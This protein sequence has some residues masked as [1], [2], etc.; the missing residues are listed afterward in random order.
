MFNFVDPFK[1][2]QSG[3]R[4]ID[5][6]VE[7]STKNLKSK[8]A[9]ISKME[10]KAWKAYLAVFFAAG[11]AAALIWAA[12]ISWYPA[13][14][15]EEMPEVT[16]TYH[17]S[18]ASRK[19]GEEFQTQIVLD[20]AGKNIVAVQTVATFDISKVEVKSVDVSSSTSDFNSE[21]EKDIDSGGGR[22]LIAV[23]RST[24]GVKSSA[25]KV[26]T[27]SMKA[28]KDFN[29]PSL[30]LKPV[31][32]DLKDSSLAVV[33]DGKGS[34]VLQKVAYDVP[35]PLPTDVTPPVRSGGSPT[36]N[37]NAGATQA[38]LKVTTNE[39]STCKHSSTAGTA[40]DT[41]S[42]SFTTTDNLNHTAN[43]TGLANGK[44]YNYY[45]R[46]KDT[47]GNVNAD[48]YQ[49]TFSV[50]VPDTTKPVVSITAPAS[51][52]TVSGKT[53]VTASATDDIGVTKVDFLVDGATKST[54]TAS[55]YTYSWDTT[56]L[57]NDSSHTLSAKACD[58][59]GNCTT[60][61]QISVKVNNAGS[62]DT[63]PPVISN[64]KASPVTNVRFWITWQTNEISTTQV[65][66]GLTNSYGSF[67]KLKSTLSL[68]HFADMSRLKR[69]TTY[70]YRVISV[71]KAGN[72]AVSEEHT[73][74]T[75]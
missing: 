38:D 21:I 40:Y 71:D 30:A 66:Y 22:I 44:T 15:A 25:A 70:H 7:E 26:A 5:K 75:K 45:V 14:R 41:I 68:S 62:G 67:T 1:T 31:S 55:P 10:I 58:A 56:S 32:T 54:V 36:G 50:A 35:P 52:A 17:S 74:T 39:N 12:Y 59:A 2:K 20:T 33:D 37:L 9:L 34:N 72:K 46:C 6:T 27:V 23:G 69:K 63:T 73:L 4:K 19:Q 28:L 53:E 13:G 24:P 18:V 65:E 64:I 60:S 51:G 3:Q 57:A 29:E 43:V 61:T 47:A 48:D 42:A 11:F 16:L 49:I 8:F